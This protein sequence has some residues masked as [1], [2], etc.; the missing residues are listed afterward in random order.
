MKFECNIIDNDCASGKT[1]QMLEK[2]REWVDKGQGVVY[3]C[4]TTELAEELF[5]RATFQNMISKDRVLIFTGSGSVKKL[6]GTIRKTKP[7]LVFVTHD[8]IIN[9]NM[10]TD[11]FK[12]KWILIH[13][14]K[15]SG[16]NIISIYEDYQELIRKYPELKDFFYTHPVETNPFRNK[17]FFDRIRKDYLR[18]DCFNKLGLLKYY[19]KKRREDKSED[20]I[21]FLHGFLLGN[22]E[23]YIK[24][25]DD[26]YNRIIRFVN[27]NPYN[28]W[29]GVYFMF[30][31]SSI[32]SKHELSF[33]RKLR[34]LNVRT[35][36]RNI[37]KSERRFD[38]DF[39]DKIIIHTTNTGRNWS[40]TY[41]TKNSILEKTLKEIRGMIPDNKIPLVLCNKGYEDTISDVFGDCV[42]MD[43]APYGKEAERYLGCD[44]FIDVAARF[45]SVQN[46]LLLTDF[47]FDS[48]VMT[49]EKT[50]DLI[51]CLMRT[52]L[53]RGLQDVFHVFTTNSI[54]ATYVSA[55]F[56]IDP[57]MDIPVF[58]ISEPTVVT[59]RLDDC[60]V[61]SE[62]SITI[63][64][65]TRDVVGKTLTSHSHAEL[66]KYIPRDNHKNSGCFIFGKTDGEGRT[67]KN[68][69]YLSALVFDFDRKTERAFS[70]EN[71]LKTIRGIFG[72]CLVFWQPTF[73]R[74]NY[75][76]IVPVNKNLTPERYQFVMDYLAPK[77]RNLDLSSCRPTQ[78]YFSPKQDF[79]KS[80]DYVCDL[81]KIVPDIFF[82]IGQRTVDKRPTYETVCRNQARALVLISGIPERR[83]P[84]TN[85]YCVGMTAKIKGLI[86][87]N[88]PTNSY[89]WSLYFKKLE[90]ILAHEGKNR[91]NDFIRMSFV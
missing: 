30:S 5:E 9:L 33:L 51:Q 1:F 76:F 61:D 65:S 62:Y 20:L 77:L 38:Y 70:G 39:S 48:S 79:I 72:E 45:S 12:K 36:Y 6:K 74:G 88:Q 11:H 54:V 78:I 91:A 85:S 66:F 57:V 35:K 31:H 10:K 29:K 41:Y 56:G 67:R 14:E 19:L 16:S 90:S 83:V 3:A 25:S 23:Y 49:W 46:Q 21:Y 40:K 84:N 87:K 26:N 71:Y 50:D 32:D 22:I 86:G 80:G 7:V 42:L 15:P 34:L 53:R 18:F 73:S 64:Q 27:Y 13:D 63:F 4:R 47:G 81:D 43:G 44:V 68:I 8:S 59:E 2:C 58:D 75:R 60:V 28:D 17:E 37:L 69:E 89:I 24:K 52:K 55:I 82:R